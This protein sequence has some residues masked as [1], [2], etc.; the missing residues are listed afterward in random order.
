M[1]MPTFKR[2][3]T[4]A[5]RDALPDDGNRY[6]VIDGELFV[7]PAPSW[8]H[9]TA[10]G[11]LY[12][13]LDDYVTAERIGY[14]FVAPADVVFSPKRGVQPDVFVVPP[15]N[16]RRPTSFQEVRRLILA[17][18]VLSPSTA[19]ADRVAKRVLFRDEGVDE[20]WIVDCDSRTFERSTPADP[21]VEIIA[22]ELT[23]RPAGAARP[24]VID[25]PAYFTRVLDE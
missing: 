6:E 25:V 22:D 14:A 24:L 10:V 23:W 9:Q 7:T 11:H 8:N 13:L 16:G 12:R 1:S 17:V 19:R 15:V 4:V 3:W 21:R 20:F 18:E 2:Q 5:D